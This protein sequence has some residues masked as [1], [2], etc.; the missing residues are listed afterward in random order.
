M[1]QAQDK[2]TALLELGLKDTSSEFA[3]KLAVFV[4]SAQFFIVDAEKS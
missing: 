3:Q 2:V 1:P 4:E